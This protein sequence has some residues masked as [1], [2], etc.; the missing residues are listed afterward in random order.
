MTHS[1]GYTQHQS[2][3]KSV[4]DVR[5]SRVFSKSRF[6]AGYT[7]IELVVAVGLFALIMMLATGAYFMMISVNR[8]AQGIATGINNLS[9]ALDSMTRDIR[10]GTAY[11]CNGL[12]DC[13]NGANNFAFINANGVLVS[14]NLVGSTIQKQIGNSP[15]NIPLTD[16]SVTI[17][18]L[19]FYANGTRSAQ[20]ADYEQPRVTII[21]S[22]TVSTG[23]GQTQTFTVETGATMRGSDI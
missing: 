13:P 5:A 1:R 11:N 21:V 14:Y 8:Q 15:Q 23:N 19:T 12:S 18:S 3:A 7:L 4:V 6:G 17:S 22:G 9:F 16:S 20:Q 2:P 10:T